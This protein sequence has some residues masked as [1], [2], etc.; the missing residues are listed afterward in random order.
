MPGRSGL[1]APAPPDVVN[2]SWLDNKTAGELSPAVFRFAAS[3]YFGT[4]LPGRQR[5]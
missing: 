2:Q 5:V 1:N 4:L 3:I